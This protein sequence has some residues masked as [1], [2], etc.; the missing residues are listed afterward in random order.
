[1]RRLGDY[2]HRWRRCV[3]SGGKRVSSSEIDFAIQPLAEL[4]TPE[5]PLEAYTSYQAGGH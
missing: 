2:I 1:M 5:P 4:L 3:K